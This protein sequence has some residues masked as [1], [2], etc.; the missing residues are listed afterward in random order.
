MAARARPLKTAS[1][2]HH[3]WRML[4]SLKGTFGRLKSVIFDSLSVNSVRRVTLTSKLID[5]ACKWGLLDFVLA[6]GEPV[7]CRYAPNPR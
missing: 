4:M 7:L 2:A 5:C 6:H 3:I 1:A